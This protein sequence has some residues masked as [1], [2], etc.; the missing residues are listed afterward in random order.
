MKAIVS[1]AIPALVCGLSLALPQEYG[2]RRVMPVYV[3][4]RVCGECHWGEDAGNQYE[5]WLHSRHSQAYA[6]LWTQESKEIAR[7]SGIPVEPQ[8]SLVCLGCHATAFDT[9][10]WER[11]ETFV[12]EDGVQCERCHGPGSEYMSA[13][14][15]RDPE[16]AMRRGLR[17]PTTRDCMMCHAEK[18]SHTAILGPSGFD[19]E[20]WMKRLSHPR[21]EWGDT[22]GSRTADRRVAADSVP[23]KTPH[24]VGNAVCGSCHKGPAMGYQFSRWRASPHAGAYASLATPRGL[25]IASDMGIDSD[26]QTHEECLS[27]HS[28]GAGLGDESLAPLFDRSD[29]VQCESCHGAGSEYAG[30]KVMSDSGA[31][32]GAGLET[33]DETMCM[34]C[35][36]DAHGAPF[37][38]A[39]AMEMIAHPTHLP[40][41]AL[42]ELY[43]TPLNLA[44]TPDGAELYVACEASDSV[45]IVDTASRKVIAEIETGGQATDVT[46]NPQ[47]TL[48]YVS[49]RLGD[50]VTVIDVARRQVIEDIKVGDEPHGLIFDLPGENLYVLDTGA[51]SISIIN[52]QTHEETRRL[53]SGRNPWS[54]ALSPDG[55]TIAVTNTLAELAELRQNSHSEV[56]LIDTATG[57][58][59][60]RIRVPDT[61]LCQGIDYH[62]SGEFL[63]ITMNRTKGL[64]PMTRLLQGWTITNGFG[65]IW[66]DGRVDQVLLDQP[67]L[68]F[69]DTADVAFSP[70]GRWAFLT[71]S[72]SDRVAVVDVEKLLSMLAA[73]S[74]YEREHVFPNHV[75]LPCE[76][77]FTHI[78]TGRSPRGVTFAPDG[79]L[80]YVA[81]SLDDTVTVID[82]SRLQP[83]ATIDLGGAKEITRI[84]W[85]EQL[86]HSADITF[87]RQFS[88]HSCHPDGNVDGITY[89]IEPDG[90]GFDPV[91][92][93]TLRG[94]LD[95][96]P[97]KWSG[98]NPSLSRQCG[99]RLAVFF[100]RIDPFTPEEL[101]ALTTYICTIP[102]PP[103]R[104]RPLGADLTPAQR[105]GKR[106]FERMYD[107]SGKVIPENGRCVTCHFPPLF[108]D[109]LRHDVG[110]LFE[111]DKGSVFDTPHLNNIYETPPY[112]HNGAALT[113]EEIWT[114]Y[115]PE[116]QH[117]VTNDMTKDQ[118]NDLIEFLKTL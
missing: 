46:F 27:C 106:M 31:A 79:K 37:D 52:A 89:D 68:C 80:A 95:T 118:L 91:D 26:P 108:T 33:P 90:I 102:R 8:E 53:V 50:T 92:N 38:Y 39:A 43:K 40:E 94:I 81:D 1:I 56:T 113:L 51:N 98:L 116:D 30:V 44:V 15:M 110:N 117:G 60:N 57:R 11:D 63:F 18:G 75:G 42:P 4:A 54:L 24:F 78:V 99:P 41:A 55:K 49:N 48:A 115:N 82:V 2:G 21:P 76:F 13:K 101:D 107:N 100:T 96:A 111:L 22:H 74:D 104:F 97:F 61:N 23:D 17:M 84:R 105:R 112:L 67:D 25:E 3:G 109:R 83:T 103:N 77:I 64:V 7:L 66:K 58:V 65:I 36:A 87:R 93:R 72:G 71:S 9:E 12:L 32:H 35:H 59:K 34:S 5:K 16:E 20:E 114:R 73:A 88:C 70:D 19:P 28:T 14:V 45:I 10:G 85:G 69:P 29:G 86:F 6:A 62:P 47:G